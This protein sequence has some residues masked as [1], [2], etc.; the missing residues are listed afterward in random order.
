MVVRANVYHAQRV[1]SSHPV[2]ER[3]SLPNV[4]PTSV[5]WL[6]GV[7]L[8]AKDVEEKNWSPFLKQ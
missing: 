6:P 1:P 3:F 8:E 2:H 7:E 4:F 5:G